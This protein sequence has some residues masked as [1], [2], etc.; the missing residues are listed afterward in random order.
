M[1]TC[2]QPLP[3]MHKLNVYRKHQLCWRA[4]SSQAVGDAML[5][6]ATPNLSRCRGSWHHRENPVA[7]TPGP[8][9]HGEGTTQT[10]TQP[11]MRRVAPSCGARTSAGKGIDWA[12]RTALALRASGSSVCDSARHVAV[13]LRRSC[14]PQSAAEL[15]RNDRE[16]SSYEYLLAAAP[17]DAQTECLQT[18][19]IVLARPL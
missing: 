13:T 3:T 4:R 17:H 11:K 14:S 12:A 10:H 6:I 15:V 9:T 5:L 8:Y 19:P 16:S 1:S 18:T 2:W 7:T